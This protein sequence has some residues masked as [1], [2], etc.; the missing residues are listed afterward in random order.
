MH[1]GNSLIYVFMCM[2]GIGDS[3][4]GFFNAILFVIFSKNVRESFKRCLRCDKSKQLE[5]LKDE[6][7]EASFDSSR[8]LEPSA[9]STQRYSSVDDDK[10]EN[11][12][13]NERSSHFY[14]TY[15]TL[16]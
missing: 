6:S 5:Q 11:P 13:R 15:G 9:S 1:V 8:M 7:V 14:T 12:L 4:Q 10:T 2:Q 16:N 3:G